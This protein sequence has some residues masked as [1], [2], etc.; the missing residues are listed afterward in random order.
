VSESS[1]ELEARR[2]KCAFDEISKAWWWFDKT[3]SN[4]FAG[5]AVAWQWELLRR[6]RAYCWEDFQEVFDRY[7]PPTGD[8][9]RNVG[10]SIENID[11][12]TVSEVEQPATVFHFQKTGKNNNGAG[13]SSVLLPKGACA[14]MA[15]TE[16][17]EL[18]I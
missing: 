15:E 7:L 8:S 5:N 10:T 18:L 11:D 4:K 3:S 6:S 14:E 17:Q 12:S 13:C 16:P 1:D 2:I 9:K